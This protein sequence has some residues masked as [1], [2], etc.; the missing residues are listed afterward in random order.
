[1]FTLVAAQET[2]GVPAKVSVGRHGCFLGALTCF[3]SDPDAYRTRILG[4]GTSQDNGAPVGHIG[5]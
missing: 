5:H 1:V 2:S 3:R 4:M